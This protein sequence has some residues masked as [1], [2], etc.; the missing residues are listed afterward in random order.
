MTVL[1]PDE[2]CYGFLRLQ[3]FAEHQNTKDDPVVRR[4]LRPGIVAAGISALAIAHFFYVITRPQR[5]LIGFVPDDAFYELQLARH[6]LAT[7]RW[8]FD[9]KLTTTT[10]FHLLNVYLMS[11]FPRLFDSPGWPLNSG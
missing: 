8:S 3:K 9:G 7:G 2:N 5:V 10:G 4:L 6:F 1:S 11:L